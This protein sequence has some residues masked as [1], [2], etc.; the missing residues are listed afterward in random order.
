MMN[1]TKKVPVPLKQLDA[2]LMDSLYDIAKVKGIHSPTKTKVLESA[3]RDYVRLHELNEMDNPY[4]IRHISSIIH[5]ECDLIEKHLGN[6]M[7]TLLS[8]MAINQNIL[9]RI[10]FD[11]MNK[12]ANNE[13]TQQ[14]LK[15]YRQR[16]VEELRDT[17]NPITYAQLLKEQDE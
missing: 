7:M 3:L 13:E 8:E 1:K 16:A 5:A 17:H 15:E 2:D 12:Y 6:R 4:L 10:I 11:F 14:L 9:N